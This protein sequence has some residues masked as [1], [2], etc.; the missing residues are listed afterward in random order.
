ML[1]IKIP[2][3]LPS[4]SDLSIFFFPEVIKKTLFWLYLKQISY[5]KYWFNFLLGTWTTL[6]F[7]VFFFLI[8]SLRWQR[9]QQ[10]WHGSPVPNGG[11]WPQHRRR[12]PASPL[13][14]PQGGQ[15]P[16]GGAEGVQ[17]GGGA[18]EWQSQ[19]QRWGITHLHPFLLILN[20][21][22]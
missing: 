15:H 17:G 22:P 8:P 14:L 10:Q 21:G 5:E 4:C 13:P 18:A 6:Y 19:R 16:V 2:S 20:F 12:H 3:L 1:N 11:R 9:R 7:C